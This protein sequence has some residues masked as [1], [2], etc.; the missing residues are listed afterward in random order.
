MPLRSRRA[1]AVA[2]FA[3]L[4]LLV[5]AL[6]AAAACQKTSLAEIDDEV[7]CPICGTPLGAAGGPQA[8]DERQFIRRLVEKCMTKQQIKAALVAEY[9]DT[10]LALPKRKGFNAIIY[11]VPAVALALAAVLLALAARRW[12][13]EP[14][15]S[16]DGGD[17]AGAGPGDR[18][19]EDELS[20][21]MDR[22]DL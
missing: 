20:S 5:T 18:D 3:C 7:M 16:A 2:L 11:V 10:V 4:A 13:R 6:P 21:D 12:R 15:S 9:G 14:P 17:A 8:E 19:G 1:F 22:Y